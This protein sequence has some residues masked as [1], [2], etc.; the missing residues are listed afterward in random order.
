MYSASVSWT[1]AQRQ[2]S[3]QRIM[4][5]ESQ[6]KNIASVWILV[7]LLGGL[8]VPFWRWDDSPH[9]VEQPL[10]WVESPEGNTQG[11]PATE[12]SPQPS[13]VSATST[14]SQNDTAGLLHEFQ[15]ADPGLQIQDAIK[16]NQQRPGIPKQFQGVGIP[17]AEIKPWLPKPIGYA[18]APT[19]KQKLA[20]SV[21]APIQAHPANLKP[22]SDFAQ[23]NPTA[24][25]T[26]WPDNGFAAGQTPIAPPTM[27]Y[28]ADPLVNAA[29]DSPAAIP[30]SSQADPNAPGRMVSSSRSTSTDP[31]ALLNTQ[32]VPPSNTA[33][34]TTEYGNQNHVKVTPSPAITPPTNP[35]RSA[36]PPTATP[37][38]KGTIISQPKTTPGP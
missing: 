18:A 23:S 17:L 5:D 13:L 35:L 3:C 30:A 1:L 8:S 36:P 20:G 38:R 25:Q 4:S 27:F 11:S 12:K 10:Q 26:E 32:P 33:T 15:S 29:S 19:E 24:G 6:P 34:A 7:V 21:N 9:K 14:T 37:H 2:A 22:Q 31:P 16:T 28:N